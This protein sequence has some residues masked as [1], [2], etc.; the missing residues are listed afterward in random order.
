[1]LDNRPDALLRI[2]TRGRGGWRI[3]WPA[4]VAT[5]DL[6]HTLVLF[7]MCSGVPP[8]PQ[9]LYGLWCNLLDHVYSVDITSRDG[10]RAQD[11]RVQC[12]RRKMVG[13][14]DLIDGNGSS[15]DRAEWMSLD[16]A[17][18][19]VLGID[20]SMRSRRSRGKMGSGPRRREVWNQ[21]SYSTARRLLIESICLYV[22]S[23][24]ISHFCRD[25]LDRLKGNKGDS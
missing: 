4:S 25:P 1:M 3:G 2:Q 6:Y 13:W 17:G 22:K 12:R 8:F 15:G 20:S 11:G 10:I 7:G 18:R 9:W 14:L 19:G 5:R 24:A 21:S 16:R 23:L